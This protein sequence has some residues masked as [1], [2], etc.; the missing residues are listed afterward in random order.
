MMVSPF[1]APYPSYHIGFD[2]GISGAKAV[3]KDLT[4][5]HFRYATNVA[6]FTKIIAVIASVSEAI[7]GNGGRA[8][9]LRPSPK[10]YGG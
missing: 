9:L 4:M 7:Q 1:V 5:I 3:Q 2:H 8:G 10:G 6:K